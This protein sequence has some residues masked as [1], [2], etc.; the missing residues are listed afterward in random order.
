[1]SDYPKEPQTRQEWQEA[2][3]AAEGA[4]ALASAREYGLVTGGPQV[5]LHRCSLIIA[6]AR[7]EHGVT[8]ARDCI[9][10][11]VH[12]MRSVLDADPS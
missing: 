10:R 6:R 7:E 2:A 12:A 9:E 8:P 1:M 4:L 11:F 3:D 5:D